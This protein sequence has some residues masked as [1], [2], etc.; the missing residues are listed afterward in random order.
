MHSK[1]N[2]RFKSNSFQHD[3]KYELKTL[4]KHISCLCKYNFDETKCK[5]NQWWN[6]NKCQCECKEHHICDKG[7]VQNPV[8]S[9]YGNGKYLANIMYD[10]VITCDEV[11]EPNDE[12]LHHNEKLL[13]VKH[14]ISTF[15]LLFY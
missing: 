8:I 10:S 3:H 12:E 2:K 9:N 7:C 1:Q 11:I 14:K 15:Q 5:L 4:I 6:N 13:S